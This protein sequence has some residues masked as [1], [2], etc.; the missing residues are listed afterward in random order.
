MIKETI[1]VEGKDDESAVKGAVKAEVIITNG[2]GINEKIIERIKNAQQRT[3]VIIFTDP[4]FPGEKIRKIIS[5]KVPGCKHAYL[6]RKHS[7]KGSNIGIENASPDHIIE[8][9]SRVKTEGEDK[10]LFTM[11]HLVDAGL[12]M[13]IAA[14]QRREK[15]GEFLGIGYGNGKQFLKR[16]NHYNITMKEFQEAL[17]KL[18]KEGSKL[19]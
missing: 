10:K 17:Q 2:L 11:Q 4:D 6:P 9:L 15:M 8:A 14:K 7:R 3:G 5:N 18:E 1:V 19:W 13:D 12:L 16:L